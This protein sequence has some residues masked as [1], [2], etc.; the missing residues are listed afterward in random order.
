[1]TFF[2]PFLETIM[3]EERICGYF[4]QDGAVAH[5]A[6]YFINVLNKVFL[7]SRQTESQSYCKVFRL[8]SV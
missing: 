3:E 4:M 1:M 8:K 6:T 2:V 5:T 7:P